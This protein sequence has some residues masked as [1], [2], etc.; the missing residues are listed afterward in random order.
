MPVSNMIFFQ[1][2]SYLKYSVGQIRKLVLWLSTKNIVLPC[3]WTEKIQH[4]VILT[5]ALIMISPYSK[6]YIFL[7][8]KNHQTL[9]L[10][11]ATL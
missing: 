6:D 3:K 2:S 4:P 8:P 5:T 7:P 1:I 9:R 10:A 11:P